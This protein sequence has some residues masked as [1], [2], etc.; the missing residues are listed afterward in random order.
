MTLVTVGNLAIVG[1][2]GE[3]FVELGLAIK[4]EPVLRANFCR[5][6]L[7]RS[8]RLYSHPRRVP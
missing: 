6:L 7:Q 3:L 2:P 5:R 4:S 8:H 1:I